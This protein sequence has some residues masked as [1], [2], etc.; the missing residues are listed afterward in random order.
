MVQKKAQQNEPSE[1]SPSQHDDDDVV[2]DVDEQVDTDKQ[3]QQGEDDNQ[4]VAMETDEN[5]KEEEVEE[6][7]IVKQK[8]QLHNKA[9]I[10]V[11]VAD[12]K[13]CFNT[14]SCPDEAAVYIAASIEA[15]V[16]DVLTKLEQKARKDSFLINADVIRIHASRY[17][18]EQSLQVS[19]RY[20]TDKVLKSSRAP[21]NKKVLVKK[22]KSNNEN[23]TGTTTT[24]TTDT[25]SNK[26]KPSIR[27]MFNASSQRL[28]KLR[29]ARKSPKS[30]AYHSKTNVHDAISVCMVNL[31]ET[32]EQ[33]CNRLLKHSGRKHLKVKICELATSSLLPNHDIQTKVIKK[34]GK[35]VREFNNNSAKIE[36]E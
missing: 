31:C 27:K 8:Q 7:Q 9:G 24:T 29:T 33:V 26:K 34:A 15:I 21:A 13:R 25:D 3:E 4:S 30:P 2:S 23:D 32:Y 19:K 17:F 1:G 6:M 16:A 14:S 5:D 10:V 36:P 18:K 28:L 22:T 12:V 35:A 20:N 11:S